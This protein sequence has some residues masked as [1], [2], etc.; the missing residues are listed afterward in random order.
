M[1]CLDVGESVSSAK[2]DIAKIS[3]HG[4]HEIASLSNYPRPTDSAS[5]PAPASDTQRAGCAV[6]PG[7][8]GRPPHRALVVG[9]RGNRLIVHFHL[10]PVVDGFL[11]G[12]FQP[13]INRLR[14]RG[15]VAEVIVTS[16][17][18][19]V[20]AV[21]KQSL[22]PWSEMKVHA[23]PARFHWKQNLPLHILAV[24]DDLAVFDR[25]CVH[26]IRRV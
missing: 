23:N 21:P 16:K 13:E 14:F 4:K 25:R 11:R 6:S 20:G 3:L 15:V 17:I 26:D 7:T 1:S 10:Q 5:N 24:N 9:S 19:R 2:V 22:L 18:N 12:K 8:N